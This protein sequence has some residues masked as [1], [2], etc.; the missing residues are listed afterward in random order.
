MEILLKKY[1]FYKDLNCWEIILKIILKVTI[2]YSHN[3]LKFQI[4]FQCIWVIKK[5]IEALMLKTCSVA[6]WK[7]IVAFVK[8]MAFIFFN[9]RTSGWSL[10]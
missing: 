1:I 3:A 10:K 4:F 2:N 5:K 8:T 9:Q 7:I 6:V